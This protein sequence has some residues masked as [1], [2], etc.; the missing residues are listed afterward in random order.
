MHK[1]TLGS[2]YKINTKTRHMAR[3]KMF[4]ICIKYVLIH[5][6]VKYYIL[7]GEN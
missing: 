2:L 6:T 7:H 4:H 3:Q 1:E 5:K